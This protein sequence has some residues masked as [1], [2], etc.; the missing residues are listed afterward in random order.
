MLNYYRKCNMQVHTL[1]YDGTVSGLARAMKP[2]RGKHCLKRNTSDQ[3]LQN[4]LPYHQDFESYRSIII[5][6]IIT[7]INISIVCYFVKDSLHRYSVYIK[8]AEHVLKISCPRHVW[9]RTPTNNISYIVCKCMYDT[10][11]TPS[12]T[13]LLFIG[14]KLKGI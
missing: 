3:N 1:H 11:P 2:I 7:I 10:S 6:I 12:S 5:I 14:S 8:F 4:Q 13:V 9:N